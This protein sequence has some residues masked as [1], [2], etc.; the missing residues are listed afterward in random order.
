MST[1]TS[2]NFLLNQGIESTDTYHP[3]NIRSC[4]QSLQRLKYYYKNTLGSLVY[5]CS[6]FDFQ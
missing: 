5:V 1:S 4:S 2:K 3:S 6:A